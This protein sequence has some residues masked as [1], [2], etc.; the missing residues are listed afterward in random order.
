M[1]ELAEA[2]TCRE[3]VEL[4]T[5]YLEAALSEPERRRFEEHIGT[6]PGCTNYIE[7]MRLVI[8]AGGR[9]SEEAIGPAAREALLDAFRGWKR[10]RGAPA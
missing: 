6:C 3:M 2:M 7:Q 5:D 1:T 10:D 8:K 9:L 4:V